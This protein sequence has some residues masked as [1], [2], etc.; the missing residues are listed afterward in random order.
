M[1]TRFLSPEQRSRYGKFTSTPSEQILAR[2][3]H[4]DANQIEEISRL[5]N[6]YNRLGFA[7][8][9]CSVRY[10]GRFPSDFNEVPDVVVSYISDQLGILSEISLSHYFV[11]ITPTYKRHTARIRAVLNLHEFYNSPMAI[12]A[13][14][15]RL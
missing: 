3:F 12:F 14:T 13:V 2:Y 6:D 10:L 4:L 7:I 11:A 9:L 5:R 15:R 8:L 1:P